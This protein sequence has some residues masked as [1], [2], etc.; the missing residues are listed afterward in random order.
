MGQYG[1][2]VNS[3]LPG[4][5]DTEML[6]PEGEWGID[7]RKAL[8]NSNPLGRIGTPTD[9]AEMAAFLASDASSFCNGADFVVDGGILAGTFS[10]PDS[11]APWEA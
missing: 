6:R 11:T 4:P 9:I 2:R 5:I 10:P 1:I 7:M 3:I 8:A